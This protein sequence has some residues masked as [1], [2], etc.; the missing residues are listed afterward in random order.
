MLDMASF[1]EQV[2]SPLQVRRG[3]RLLLVVGE[4]AT[5][6]MPATPLHFSRLA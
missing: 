1:Q 4:G 3:P 6:A 5:L 2:L